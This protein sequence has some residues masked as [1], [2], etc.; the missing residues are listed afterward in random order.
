MHRPFSFRSPLTRHALA[1]LVLALLPIVTADAQG[2]P[3]V[4]V[5]TGDIT[6]YAMRHSTSEV[7][8]LTRPDVGAVFEVIAVGGDHSTYR[9]SNHYLVLLPRDPWGTQWVGW[10]RGQNVELLPPRQPV[11]TTQSGSMTTVAAASRPGTAAPS[12]PPAASTTG[13]PGAGTTAAASPTAAAASAPMPELVLQFAFD[14]SDLAEAAKHTL[15]TALTTMSGGTTGL[16]FSLG[17]H[18]DATGPDTYNQKLGLARAGAV[19]TYI[20]EQLKVP[21]ERITVSSYGEARP[22]ASNDNPSGRA[23]NRRVV[24]TVT[25]VTASAAR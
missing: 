15:T 18:A 3:Q 25:P 19:R 9:E 1:G 6:I 2:L 13:A 14:R 8:K 17:G 23:E 12:R 21:A 22:V 16:A 11:A 5:T 7:W 24:V 10:I 20:I 4:R